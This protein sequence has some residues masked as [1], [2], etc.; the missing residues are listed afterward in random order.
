MERQLSKG[1]AKPIIA[2][3]FATG[4]EIKGFLSKVGDE[5]LYVKVGMELYYQN[6]PDVVKWI[7]DRGHQIF[8]DL[9]LHDIPNTVHRAM[10]G[11]AALD[12]DMVNVHASG[13][14]QMMQAAKEGVEEGTPTGSSVPALIAVTQLTSTTEEE[15]QSQQ[16]IRVSLKESVLNYA[17]LTQAA[18]LDGVVCSA[19]EAQDIKNTTST[20]FL[21]VTPGI[22]PAGSGHGDQKRV[23]T[24]EVARSIGST[25][26]VVGRPITQAPDPLA[27]YL[28]IKEQWN[29]GG[30][31]S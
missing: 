28:A 17:A 12:I 9:K 10:K 3:D 31:Q 19:W 5:K 25:F 30:Q 29:K 22:R 27:A 16:L 18:G 24:P 11:L 15:M 4:D 21:C 13:G 14:L 20:D 26:I 2:L 6:G 23:A 7:K 8:L 1:Q